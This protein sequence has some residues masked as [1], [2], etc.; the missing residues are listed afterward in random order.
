MEQG[1]ISSEEIFFGEDDLLWQ[2]LLSQEDLFIK[3]RMQRIL[4]ADDYFMQVDNV[5]MA[6]ECARMKFR[7][8]DPLIK[9]GGEI[10]RLTEIDPE[11]AEEYKSVKNLMEKGWALK[12]I[13]EDA[14]LKKISL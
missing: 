3:N 11:I 13:L 9:I 6:D 14:K 1:A 10:K 4:N 5:E 2:K 7:G 8:I 12:F